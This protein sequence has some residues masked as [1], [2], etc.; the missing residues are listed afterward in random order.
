MKMGTSYACISSFDFIVVFY[1][2][3]MYIQFMEA[4]AQDIGH[5]YTTFA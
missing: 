2:F 4:A 5:N 3:R 1:N